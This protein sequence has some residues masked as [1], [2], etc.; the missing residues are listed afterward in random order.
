MAPENP[1]KL[2]HIERE[3]LEALRRTL[4]DL[5]SLLLSKSD[6]TV[7]VGKGAESFRAM[8]MRAFSELK[9]S[10]TLYVIGASG[11]DYYEVMGELHDDIESK[12]IKKK[13]HKKLI[14][15]ENMREKMRGEIGIKYTH[16][17]FL[18]DSYPISSSTNI[19]G[20]TVVIVIWATDPIV[21]S[22]KSEE[23]AQSYKQYFNQLWKVAEF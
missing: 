10:D 9:K 11:D 17:R 3:R 13:I 5:K 6:S 23:V 1:E 18:D 14:S 16:V 8:R 20:N 4:P 15:F 12:R 2:E 7:T 22:I 21:I 19:F